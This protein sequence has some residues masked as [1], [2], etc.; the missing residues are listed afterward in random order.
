VA[1]EEEIA[2]EW[3]RLIEEM[4]ED[5]AAECPAEFDPTRELSYTDIRGHTTPDQG[6][7]L[8]GDSADS[9]EGF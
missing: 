3:C 8:S 2:D 7:A 5:A 9:E 1:R 4:E 6:R